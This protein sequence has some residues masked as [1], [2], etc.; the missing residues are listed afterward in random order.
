[1]HS[2]RV[3]IF[4]VGSLVLLMAIV[5]RL[6]QLQLGASAAIQD[7]IAQLKDQGGRTQLLKTVR[8][9]ILDRH[10]RVLA[11]DEPIFALRISYSLS[12]YL[13]ERVQQA[14]RLDALQS[15]ANA[16]DALLDV[17]Q[18][19]AAR[20]EVL[21]EVIAR[22]SGFGDPC[23]VV[24]QRIR[25]YNNRIWDQ[26]SFQAW[27]RNCT[28]SPFYKQN[29]DRLLSVD[30]GEALADLERNRPD[31][32][33]R[34][35]LAAAVD[36]AEMHGSDVLVQ[37]K[38]DE[39]VL[40]AQL[41]FMHVEEISIVPEPVRVYPYGATAAQT[42][43]WVGAP[44]QESDRVLFEDDPYARYLEGEVCGREDGVEFVCEAVLRG[45]RGRVV[46]DIDGTESRRIPSRLGQDVRLTIDIELQ[47]TLEQDLL[48]RPLA[49]HCGPGVAAVVL[50]VATGDILALVSLPTY[51]LNR[52]R[53]E[54]DRLKGDPKDPN[55]P[56]LNRALNKQYPPGS[57]VKPTILVAA[58]QTGQ[59]STEDVISCPSRRAP[60]GW[61]NCWV[62]R[63]HGVGH[64]T[65]WANTARNALKGSCNIYFS[66]LADRID[67]RTL[68]EWLWAFGYG[69]QIALAY[70]QAQDPNDEPVLQA[71][72]R[73][74][75]QAAGQISSQAQYGVWVQSMDQI[76]PLDPRDRA[77][78]GIG[79]N[80]FW[81]TPLQVAAAMAAVARGGISKTPRLFLDPVTESGTPADPLGDARTLGLAAHTLDTLYDGLHAVVHEENGT[82]H[83][84]FRASPL[85]ELGV[86]VYGKTGSTERPDHA[87][88][89][90]FA[91]DGAGRAVA[92]A[93]VVEG[94][95]SGGTDVAPIGH[96]LIRFCAQA[97]Y[98]GR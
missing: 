6:A 80:K 78:V 53:Y 26:R 86:Q 52:A 92:L 83:K 38:T 59:I 19:I 17:N 18:A 67:P 49:P 98:L 24:E 64:D 56:L 4:A 44:S 96:D 82:A 75:R 69:H 33:D 87:W 32:N 8:G 20:L 21:R 15:K 27:R 62:F 41:E 43:G 16:Q 13:D 23:E 36:I 12:R 7:K 46:Y 81:A 88:F 5:A 35:R 51:D 22:C 31:P 29:A 40:A 76:L 60:E 97:G 14:L 48:T 95:Q 2:L 89:A 79:E 85:I 66:R 45:R 11:R 65:Y 3:R 77:L 84:A 58:L 61:P 70:P 30:L 74:L 37:L 54:Y 68:Q 39:D 55:K 94:G 73:R 9:R 93:V 57:V 90:G 71:F 1:M 72:P 47:K 42:I 50:E 63:D 34:I 10:D 28:D 91:R 25:G